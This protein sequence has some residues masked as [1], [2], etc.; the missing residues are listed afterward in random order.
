MGSN[1]G[2]VNGMRRSAAAGASDVMGGISASGAMSDSTKLS[3][4]S[5]ASGIS[6]D[7][8]SDTA[9]SGGG[10]GFGQG[11][12]Q[13]QGGSGALGGSTRVNYEN[14]YEQMQDL[15]D[16]I[17]TLQQNS[18]SPLQIAQLTAQHNQL[19]QQYYQA[20]I[21]ASSFG[22]VQHNEQ[23]GWSNEEGTEKMLG[24]DAD[25]GNIFDPSHGVS[26]NVSSFFKKDLS[27]Q[28]YPILG[29]D[30]T[31]GDGQFH[32]GEDDRNLSRELAFNSQRI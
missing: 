27:P 18:G 28:A 15:Q 5:D 11:S 32:A 3:T 30:L 24:V 22:G 25:H 20:R 31:Y 2:S 21:K 23:D 16:Q 10:L 1:G 17:Q 7:A 12:D 8:M 29:G 26:E 14:L 6:G 9:S 4:Q 13:S 19:A